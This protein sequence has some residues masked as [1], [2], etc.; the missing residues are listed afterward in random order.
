MR[1]DAAASAPGAA[2]AAV[3][4]AR[5]ETSYCFVPLPLEV[6]PVVLSLGGVVAG[7][8]V[9]ADGGGVMGGDADGVRSPEGRSPRR[10]LRD[11]PQAVTR[12]ALSASA[13]RPVSTFFIW[14]PPC[15]WVR[16]TRIQ[17]EGLQHTCP[18]GR[19]IA[20]RVPAALTGLGT[21]IT[22]AVDPQGKGETS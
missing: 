2:E 10:S 20:T 21:T 16:S 12:P 6:E 1:R 17:G 8:G 18:P 14:L 22:N 9:V 19:R 3:E 4:R 15:L 5:D 13:H 11:S 7:G